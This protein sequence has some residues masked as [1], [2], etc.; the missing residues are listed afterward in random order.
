[1]F[2]ILQCAGRAHLSAVSWMNNTYIWI[3][4]L[5]WS[6]KRTGQGQTRDKQAKSPRRLLEPSQQATQRLVTSAYLGS[7][8]SLASAPGI[9]MVAEAITGSQCSQITHRAEKKNTSNLALNVISNP[10]G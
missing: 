8:A 2:S 5:N 6:V 10:N 9:A 1:M 4:K 7:S 3:R